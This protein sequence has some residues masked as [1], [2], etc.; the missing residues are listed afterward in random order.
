[1]LPGMP[2]PMGQPKAKAA[3]KAGALPQFGYP[4]GGL[5]VAIATGRKCFMCGAKEGSD[6]DPWTGITV[7]LVENWCACCR[8][9]HKSVTE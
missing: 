9:P 1:M 2:L 8:T 5:G 6:K 4:V 3:A 7:K